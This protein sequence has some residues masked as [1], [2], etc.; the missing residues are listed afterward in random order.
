VAAHDLTHR[1]I[2]F[3]AAQQVVFFGRHGSSREAFFWYEGSVV[4]CRW[5]VELGDSR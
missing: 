4:G 3:D 1:R 2:A 5:R